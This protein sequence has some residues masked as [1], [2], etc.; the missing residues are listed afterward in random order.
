MQN[1]DIK[2][3]R[4]INYII[5]FVT[6]L[7]GFVGVLA[8]LETKKHNKINDEVLSL[9]KQIKTLELEIK[10]NEARQNGIVD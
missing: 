5:A 7:T 8:Y 4:S 6:I 9:D 3:G 2:Q 1:I 10:K